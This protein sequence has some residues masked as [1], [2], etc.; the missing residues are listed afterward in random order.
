MLII[1]ASSLF[2]KGRAQN[3]L[4]QEHSDQIVSWYRG[5]EDVENRAKLATLEEIKKEGW[6]L[7]I[8]RYV[9]PPIGQD[10]PPLPEAVEAFKSALV[11]ARAA[12]DHLRKVLADGGWLQ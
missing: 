8:S 2:R 12:E 6:T 1:D 3:L 5:F 9:M 11:D 7:N 4:E 10:I